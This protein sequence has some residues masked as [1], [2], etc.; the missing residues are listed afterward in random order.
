M[1]GGVLKVIVNEPAEVVMLVAMIL[2]SSFTVMPIFGVK[3]E[4]ET[5]TDDPGVTLVGESI[6]E[7]CEVC[8]TTLKFAVA[9]LRLLE[10]V[11]M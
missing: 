4:P 3:L 1:L 7:L 10:A 9:V 8:V 5:V 11:I 6:I 2:L